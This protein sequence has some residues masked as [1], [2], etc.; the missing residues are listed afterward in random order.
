MQCPHCG[1]NNPPWVSGCIKCNT[2]L[3]VG[4][5]TITGISGESATTSLGGRY[6]L[7]QLL[8]EGGMGA[9]FKA[10]DRELNRFVALKVIH[11]ELAKNPDILHRFKQELILARE[12]THRNVVRIYDL[13]EAEGVKFLTM[14]Y[15]E[16]R[17]LKG[18]L[19]EKGRFPP[20]EAAG[21]IEQVCHALEAA[22]SAGVIHRDLKPQNI[23]VGADGK[24]SV[25]DFGIARSAR[26]TEGLTVTGALIGTPQYMSP[27]QAK[28]EKL[29]SRTDLFS[30]G[31]VFYELLTGDVPY[32]ADTAM[33]SLVK[34]STEVAR[35][36][37]EVV[38]EVPRA[39][40]NIVSKC[41]ERDLMRRYQS[42]PEILADLERCRG[43]RSKLASAREA[44][45]AVRSWPASKWVAAGAI[46][47]GLAFGVWAIRGRP[48]SVATAKAASA[49]ELSLAVLPFHNRTTDFSLDWLGPSIADML[50]T[51]V[52]QSTRLRIVSADRVHQILK[53][54]RIAANADL[55]LDPETVK[56]IAEL[57]SADT[58]LAGQY[59][60]FGGQIR[61]DATLL[62]LK[63]DRRAPLTVEAASENAIPATVDSLAEMIRK[64]LSVSPDVVKELKA[65]SFQP[66]SKSVA[67]LRDYNEGVQLLRDG[68]NLEAAKALQQTVQEDSRFALAY[69]RLAETEMVLGY[70]MDAEKHSRMAVQLAEDLPAREK[71]LIAATQARVTRDYGKAV[72]AYENLAAA[73]PN[74]PEIQLE[75]A[76][77]YDDM[78]EFPK[79][80]E[81]YSKVLAGDPRHVDALLAMG[82]VEIKSGNPQ[83]ALEYLN[84]GLT[85]AIQLENEEE[86]AAILQAMGISYL[87]LGKQDEALSNV[88]QSLEIK[89]RLA[90]KRG[91]AASFNAMAEIHANMGKR[92][93]AL[94]EYQEAL[95]LR[96]E[97][98]DKKGAGDTLIDL[99]TFYNYGGQY[100]EAL[101]HFKE[102]LQIQ[103]ELGSESNQGLCLN[104][105]GTLYLSKGDFE[106][107]LT[108]FQQAL[109]LRE[110]SAKPTDV[111]ETLYNLAETAES[112]GQYDKA[113]TWY[114]RSLDLYRKANDKRNAAIAS[115]GMG[116][117]FESQGRFGA[118]LTSIQD[119]L[120]TFTELHDRT[121]WMADVM[122]GYG[123]A[124]ADSGRFDDAQKELDGALVLAREL[125]IDGF[126]AQ[127]LDYQGECAFYRG[128]FQSARVFFGQALQFA[129]RA[130]EQDT[131]LQARFHQATVSLRQGRA[132]EAAN[133][134]RKLTA[135]ADRIGL[136]NLSVQ[137]SVYL[138]D[139]LIQTKDYDGARREL[140][141]SA[142]KAEKLQLRA[143]LAQNE[144]MLATALR[145]S[146][147]TDEATSHYREALRYVE[148][149]RKNTGSDAFLQRSDLSSISRDAVRYTQGANGR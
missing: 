111:A 74:D 6:E 118:A 102:S 69:A 127:A 80:A 3:G 83:P 101:G 76:R 145:L 79:A 51:D 18:L 36:P 30:L 63:R 7:L 134:L 40:S 131:A 108:Y 42:A 38:P 106:N 115:Y 110:K 62:D 57:A 17:D 119:A 96:R 44:I 130:K 72:E 41:L 149:I 137:S 109:Q 98:G 65:S 84:R 143:V 31:I 139:A 148:E 34:R 43:K 28:G 10:R 2:P 25:M 61:I 22:H 99:G 39:L 140:E 46:A 23:M 120:N 67:A 33:A 138:G 12:V 135:E 16:G 73:S 105:I 21:I 14:E 91:I 117:L 60:K 54:L 29:D 82:R 4:D 112:L 93:Q 20:Q 146:G 136:K 124:L 15:I 144:Y 123:M 85:L 94:K 26:E 50:A 100:D 9:V 47:A 70:E 97:I 88:Q 37:I 147:K 125:K 142:T 75:L 128:D 132:A 27:E 122:S 71:Y 95:R 87:R 133:S 64:N 129:T 126:I 78:G 107:A 77:L 48:S 45:H 58:V 90:D 59:A 113:I 55:V 141:S 53:D 81:H 11:A 35:A 68:K 92:G 56:R 103:R 8:G 114:E 24:V 1:L 116:K 52:G 13:G 86:K 5:R 66:A 104:N 121:S 89:Q 19:H 32:K 49:P